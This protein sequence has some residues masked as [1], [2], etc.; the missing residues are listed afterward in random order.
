MLITIHFSS[1]YHHSSNGIIERQFRTIRDALNAT[2]KDRGGS[3]WVDIL[4]EIEFSI[5]VSRQSTTGVSP[6]EVILGKRLTLDGSRHYEL[7][8]KKIIEEIKQSEASKSDKSNTQRREYKE[9]DL[10]LVKIENR[11]KGTDR[12]EGPYEIIRKLHDRFVEMKNK[13]R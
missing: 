3:N 9:G 2:L 12:Y 11:Q 5:N 7:D 10:V 13:N 6:A 4:P 8:N 1:P